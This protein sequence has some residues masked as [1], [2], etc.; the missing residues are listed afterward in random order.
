MLRSQEELR[1][2]TREAIKDPI[3]KDI[4]LD[5]TDSAWQWREG[6]TTQAPRDR[7]VTVGGQ[8]V[9]GTT[10]N[11]KAPTTEG[12]QTDGQGQTASATKG[13][14][15]DKGDRGPAGEAGPA[16]ATGATGETGETGPQG[17][18][19]PTIN[20]DLLPGLNAGDYRHLTAAQ[21][22]ALTGGADTALHFH[23]SDRA[24]ANHTG[25]QLAATI[26]DFASAADARIAAQKEVA[27][28]IAPLGSDTKIPLAY[29]PATT[30]VDTSVVASQTAMLA[31]VAQQG[32]VAVRTDLSKT[33]ILKTEPASTLANW[34]ELLS[35]TDAVV[36][37]FGRTGPVTAQ[38]G[39]YSAFY[40]PLDADLAAIAALA[41]TGFVRRT[42]ADT[43]A[44]SAIAWADIS[45]AISYGT[46]AGTVCQGNDSR[47]SDPR[48][49]TAHALD[50]ALHTVSGK[51]AGQMLLATAATTFGFVA[52]SGDATLSG[53]GALTLASTITAGSGGSGTSVPVLTWDAKGRLTAVGAAAITPAWANITGIPFKFQNYPSE[54]IVY[55]GFWPSGVTPDNNNFT[56]LWNKAGSDACFSAFNQLNFQT[57]GS[58]GYREQRLAITDTEIKA[59]V[60]ISGTTASFSSRC[61]QAGSTIWDAGNLAFG[62]GNSNMARGD[63]NHSGTYQP[64]GSYMD[65]SANQTAAGIKTFSSGIE[66]LYAKIYGVSSY[67]KILETN[68]HEYYIL[69]SIYQ[70]VLASFN[71]SNLST[72][73]YRLIVSKVVSDM[74]PLDDITYSLGSPGARWKEVNA[75]DAVFES[76]KYTKEVLT[77]GSVA[78][79]TDYET[80]TALG[81]VSLAKLTT[82]QISDKWFSF[83]SPENVG[84]RI[85]IICSSPSYGAYLVTSS[86]RFR[87]KNGSTSFYNNPNPPQTTS[88]IWVA[89]GKDWYEVG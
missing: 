60:A 29:L 45:G 31:L 16:G 61:T 3:L 14:K 56:L 64:A 7:W 36:S 9:K 15:G 38:A 83:P 53:A 62:T 18:A 72:Y 59:S 65:L 67:L 8:T 28:G 46:T 6:A 58:G 77:L 57:V 41:T 4:L 51:T 71:V 20:H 2:R 40:Q 73:I 10:A 48:I 78:G 81:N 89:D 43:W 5:L 54:P 22:S 74:M 32:D 17:P 21:Y 52:M 55:E 24:R 82:G 42:A 47:L 37:V 12:G 79:G 50:G 44:A 49:P 88:S 85:S 34:Q 30:I 68:T 86:G 27:N 1:R 70:H 69:G 19:G 35:P 13:E 63:H 39:D 66:A 75:M 84:L 33:F 11:E 80:A 87:Y 23:A 25:T 76:V 26:S